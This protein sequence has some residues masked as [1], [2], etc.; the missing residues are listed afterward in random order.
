MTAL[1][2]L[3]MTAAFDTLDHELLLLRLERQFGLCG[4]VLRWF[5]SYL[6]G[7]CFGVLYGGFCVVYCL[8]NVLGTARVSS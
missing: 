4:I 7:R 2:L 6:S 5:Q 1:C 3:D 8:H